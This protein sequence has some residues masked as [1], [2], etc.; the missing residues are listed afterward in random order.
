MAERYVTSVARGGSDAAAG[1]LLAPWA[2]VTK[3]RQWVASPGDTGYFDRGVTWRGED[4]YVQ[5]AGSSGNPITYT[6]YGTGANPVLDGSEVKTG[7]TLDTGSVY[8]KVDG[9]DPQ[10][11]FEDGVRPIL[12]VS[13]AAMVEGSWFWDGATSRVYVWCTDSAAPSTHVMEWSQLFSLVASN[14]KSDIVWDGID[15]TKTRQNG[16]IIYDSTE[17]WD[18]RDF[19]VSWCSTIGV[20]LGYPYATQDSINDVVCTN[21][22]SHDNLDEGFTF[23]MGARNGAVNCEFYNIGDPVKGYTQAAGHFFTGLLVGNGSVDAFVI[24]CYGHSCNGIATIY[25]EHQNAAG[26]V[27]PLRT[28]IQGC[29][30]VS[31]SIL[32]AGATDGIIWDSGEDTLAT[33]NTLAFMGAGG[34]GSCIQLATQGGVATESTGFQGY[35]NTCYCGTATDGA[36]LKI[37]KAISPTLKNNIFACV[38]G[39]T[40]RIIESPASAF[41]GLVMDYNCFPTSRNYQYLGTDRA[42]LALWRTDSGQDANSI[43]ADP[44]FRDAPNEDFRLSTIPTPSPAL[45]IGVVIAGVNDGTGGSTAY[46]GTAPDLGR[47]ELTFNDIRQDIIDG[48]TSSGAEAGGWNAQVR[49]TLDVTAVV[50]TSDTIVTITLPAFPA[51]AITAPEIVTVTV[52][53]VAVAGGDPIVATPAFQISVVTSGTVTITALCETASGTALITVLP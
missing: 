3:M 38:A 18:L 25:I 37:T 41:T 32:Q 15:V 1:T 43:A 26:N 48:L 52:P 12:A 23:T 7:F 11:I 29:T 13:R 30:L 14:S 53:G 49:D 51:Y 9:I 20:R 46:S 31:D 2:T 40:G 45:N 50:R 22:V 19:T 17:R 24:D 44:L 42:T 16:F 34:S 33:F 4:F 21:V 8:Y 35:H 10:Q 28:V 27:K 47:F 36:I 6:S 5:Q 39:F